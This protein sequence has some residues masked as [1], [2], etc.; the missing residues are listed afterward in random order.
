VV[1]VVVRPRRR[2][3]TGRPLAAAAGVNVVNLL[4]MLAA[5]F[6]EAIAAAGG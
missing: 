4:A 3:R 2:R 5:P 6:A 1:A